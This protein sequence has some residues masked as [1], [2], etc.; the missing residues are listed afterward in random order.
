[1]VL[2]CAVAKQREKLW[3][4]T[5]SLHDGKFV[6]DYVSPFLPTKQNVTTF[7]RGVVNLVQRLQI[8]AETGDFG[9]VPQQPSPFAEL[10]HPD[11]LSPDWV[12]VN[13]FGESRAFV[14]CAGLIARESSDL[15]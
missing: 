5:L 4:F 14:D 15:A 8:F 6:G 12:L 13:A 10:T 9:Q 1:L 3:T 2:E 11:A 7:N